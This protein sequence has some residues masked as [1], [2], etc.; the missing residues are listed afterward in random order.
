MGID[1][2]NKKIRKGAVKP[3]HVNYLSTIIF[4]LVFLNAFGAVY[5]E[6]VESIVKVIDGDTVKVR[7]LGINAPEVG[8]NGS[9]SDEGGVKAKTFLKNLILNK[10]VQIERDVELEDRYG[11][12]LAHLFLENGLHIN[13]EILRQGYATVA[14]HPPNLKY[15]DNLV[16]AQSF[17]EERGLG[18]WSL[19]AY[20]VRNVA[21]IKE[22]Q[23]GRWGR[24]SG[25]VG[26]LTRLQKGA[27]LWLD[28][29]FYVWISRKNFP[30]FQS[31]EN[32]R[33]RD[34]EVRGWP[35]KRGR[36]WSINVIHPSQILDQP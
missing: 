18:I 16:R 24:I 23:L 25:K 30:Y 15:V 9:V 14:I 21:L 10:R 35:K 3:R 7:L 29:D 34:I 26:G 5:A 22:I 12:R 32:Y 4:S 1:Y 20:E 31:I 17:A 6:P 13:L 33:G 19:D 11:R 28:D 8:Y 2:I 27:K 36:Y